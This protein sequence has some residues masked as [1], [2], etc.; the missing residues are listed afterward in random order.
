MSD[1]ARPDNGQYAHELAE[2]EAIVGLIEEA[3]AQFR[4][5]APIAARAALYD[6]QVRIAAV[7]RGEAV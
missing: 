2:C 7:M 3:E 5:A 4:A 1:T 6:A